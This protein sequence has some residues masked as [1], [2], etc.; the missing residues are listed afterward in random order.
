V[1]NEKA[2]RRRLKGHPK[3]ARAL[4]IP[5]RAKLAMSYY[6][7]PLANVATW[8]FRSKEV[9]N[10]TYDLTSANKRYLA[11]FVANI[12]RVSFDTAFAY[13]LEAE[14]N[15]DLCD[16]IERATLAS[17]LAYLADRTPKF[18]RRLG[19]Y[20]LARATKPAVIVETGVE[21]G[22]GGCLLVAALQKNANEGAPGRYYGTDIAPDAGYLV[23]GAYSQPGRILYGDSITS[24]NALSETVD[25][26]INDS[27]HSADYEAAE[28]R[29][30]AP[31]L[32]ARALVIGDN[33]HVSTSLLDFAQ[34]TGRGFAYFQ[35]KPQ[36]HW[37]PGGGIGVAFPK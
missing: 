15:H 29:A 28:Y 1:S 14:T 4:L 31:K 34:D 23:S 16:H 25:L 12:A 26:F 8:L 11:A 3:I 7:G 36:G 37:Y 6:A 18:G 24:L 10:F 27:D 2:P 5:R 35:E 19:W 9:T 33:A 21:K 22:L 20:M 17:G 30:I 32:S 13:L